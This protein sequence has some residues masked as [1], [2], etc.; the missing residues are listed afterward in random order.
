MFVTGVPP[1][2]PVVTAEDESSN[3]PPPQ[4]TPRNLNRINVNSFAKD[5]WLNQLPYVG[6]TWSNLSLSSWN[7][8]DAS[9][10]AA[11]HQT[12]QQITRLKNKLLSKDKL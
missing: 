7:N 1:H 4:P 11:N 3:F 10:D 12:H 8:M 5:E 6:F 9:G 2:L